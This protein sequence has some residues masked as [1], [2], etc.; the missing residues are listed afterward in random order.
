M[1]APQKLFQ[2]FENHQRTQK[3][4]I[5]CLDLQIYPV[6]VT[7]SNETPRRQ[8]NTRVRVPSACASSKKL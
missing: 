2:N 1:E 6:R 8:H 3:E 4:K 5:F 7:V